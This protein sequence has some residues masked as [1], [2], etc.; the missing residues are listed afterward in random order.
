MSAKFSKKELLLIVLVSILPWLPIAFTS[1][2]NDDYQ[3]IGFHTGVNLG[4]LFKPF[5]TT[6]ISGFYWR[7]LGNF[8]HVLTLLVFGFSHVAFRI[9]N[10]ALYSLCCVQYAHTSLKMGLNKN[11]ALTSAIIFALLPA[12][13][14]LTGWIAAKGE[15]LLAIFL[16]LTVQNYYTALKQ[17]SFKNY[18][19]A[20]LFFCLAL[21]VKELAFAVMFVPAMFWIANGRNKTDVKKTVQHTV[22]AVATIL[23]YLFARYLIVS[24]T[25]F[26]SPHF[27]NKNIFGYAVNFF[28]YC[29]ISFINPEMLSGR[30]SV[31][32]V[33]GLVAII[34]GVAYC[35]YANRKE[36]AKEKYY[37]MLGALW[38]VVF[39]IPVLPTLMRWYP[40]TASAGLVWIPAIALSKAFENKKNIRK[41][42]AIAAILVAAYNFN[43]MLAWYNAGIKMEGVIKQIKN[44]NIMHAKDSIL[45]F[46]SPD[47][48]SNV[49][50]M[51]LGV[52][53]TFEY[54]LQKKAEVFAP[55]RA[56][57]DGKD[58]HTDLLSANDTVVVLNL[59][60]GAFL[61]EGDRLNGW[62]KEK[63]K[64]ADVDKIKMKITAS[65]N[66]QHSRA[67]ISIDKKY[68]NYLRVYFDGNRFQIIQPSSNMSF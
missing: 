28:V 12:H 33:L 17:N 35:W 43:T 39:I 22:V 51:K 55:L 41:I 63:E 61:P 42:F 36:I 44:S 5:Y 56:E 18:G 68:K 27:Y 25:P 3:I 14:F 57:L 8:L 7:P 53:Q 16:L 19:Y 32:A 45:V 59:E 31:I 20:Y 66:F 6:D 54:A 34:A 15:F 23:F 62:K 52:E 49:P 11:A 60:K 47:K 13:G 29:V 10:L 46:A 38:F 37:F 67:E 21:L 30:Y 26:T 48:I 4:T 58:S 50:F 2:L 64:Y 24:G 65:K 9:G 1:F 40:F